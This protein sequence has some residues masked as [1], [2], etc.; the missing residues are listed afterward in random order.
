MNLKI[1]A[2]VQAAT[3]EMVDSKPNELPTEKIGAVDS[4]LKLEVQTTKEEAIDLKPKTEIQTAKGE[5]VDSKHNS[6]VIQIAKGEAVDSKLE[7]EFQIADAMEV[8]SSYW[9]QTERSSCLRKGGY[10][11]ATS[12]YTRIC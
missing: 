12:L 2:E 5:E 10:I 4:K 9:S 11:I 7:P 6:E 3:Q 8:V 1:D